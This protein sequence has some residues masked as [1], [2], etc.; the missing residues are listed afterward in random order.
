MFWTLVQGMSL[1]CLPDVFQALPSICIV[2]SE[3]YYAVLTLMQ[4]SCMWMVL[5]G[6]RVIFSSEL[7]VRKGRRS[8]KE[9]IL[10][11]FTLPLPGLYIAYNQ[12]REE[13][14]KEIRDKLIKYWTKFKFWPQ[15]NN[16]IEHSET[17]IQKI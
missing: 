7:M 3:I 15:S 14:T 6:K 13:K 8:W 4:F 10:Y 2:N 5:S 17:S 11:I 16:K 1:L 9:D 12:Y